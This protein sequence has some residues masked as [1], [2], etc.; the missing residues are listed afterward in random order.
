VVHDVALALRLAQ[1]P[2]LQYSDEPH[3]APL[4]QHGWPTPPQLQTLLAQTSWVPVP[5]AGVAPVQQ[6]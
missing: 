3:A 4:A 2:P 5:H 6:G 1:R